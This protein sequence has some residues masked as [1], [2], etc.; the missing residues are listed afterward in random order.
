MSPPASCCGHDTDLLQHLA[1]N[2]ADTKL[3]SREIGDRLDLLAEPTPIWVPVLPQGKPI[4][5]VF[6]KNSLPNSMPPP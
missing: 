4:T 5:P 6:L 2:A 3:Q 1:G